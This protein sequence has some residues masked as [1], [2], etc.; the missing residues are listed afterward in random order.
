[1]V[2]NA[3]IMTTIRTFIA[4][5]LT[6]AARI[7]LSAL[8]SRLKPLMPRHAVRWTATQNIHLT[9]HFL[10]E[11][12]E[13][14]IAKIHEAM[15]GSSAEYAPFS[16]S[17]MGLGCFPN[18]RR[19]RIVWVDLSGDT[20][21][22][23][24]LQRHLGQMLN[25]ATGFSPESRPYAPHLT[26]GRVKKGLPQRQLTPVGRVIEQEQTNVGQLATLKVTEIALIKSELTP[27]GPVYT[28]LAQVRLAGS[29]DNL[30]A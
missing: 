3:A 15:A 4:I 14:A 28:P 6:E 2:Y 21:P 24:E 8:Q 30:F 11:V 16:L 25:Q 1:M 27:T 7:A 17:L 5:E 20:E 10:G 23:V 12:E 18:T 29:S 9:L 13:T 22:L 26:I 19:P